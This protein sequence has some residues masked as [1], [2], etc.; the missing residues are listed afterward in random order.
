MGKKGF[1]WIFHY[2]NNSDYELLKLSTSWI[3]FISW[4]QAALGKNL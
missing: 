3:Q 2:E 4:E 1:L